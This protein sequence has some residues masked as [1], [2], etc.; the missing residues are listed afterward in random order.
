MKHIFPEATVYNLLYIS[1]IVY[2]AIGGGGF[3]NRR[4]DGV[5]AFDCKQENKYF[6][7]N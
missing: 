5:D 4:I 7:K 6:I 3:C 1:H 2:N